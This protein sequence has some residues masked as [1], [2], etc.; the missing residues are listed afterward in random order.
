MF[1]RILTLMMVAAMSSNAVNV[2]TETEPEVALFA[3]TE[4]EVTLFTQTES[5]VVLNTQ[6]ESE[7]QLDRKRKRKRK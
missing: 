1:K 2:N 5:E 7:G 3:Q 4:P 6:T